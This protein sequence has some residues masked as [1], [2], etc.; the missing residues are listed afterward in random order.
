MIDGVARPDPEL[1]EAH[2]ARMAEIEASD[3]PAPNKLALLAEVTLP[4]LIRLRDAAATKRE[5]KHYSQRIK[6][7]RIL[8]SW[9]K[10]RAGY[11]EL[12]KKRPDRLARALQCSRRSLQRRCEERRHSCWSG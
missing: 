9:A 1:G 2:A 11:V 5:R 10:T 3:V 7:T 12:K 6:T 8:L 4:E